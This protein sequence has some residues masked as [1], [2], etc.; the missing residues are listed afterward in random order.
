M[1]AVILLLLLFPHT[2]PLET[3]LLILLGMLISEIY[4]SLHLTYLRKQ[5]P[6]TLPFPLPSG[7]SSNHMDQVILRIALPVS[8]A[9]FFC[10]S[11]STLNSVIIPNLLVQSGLDKTV[12]LQQ[13]GVLFGMTLPLLMIPFSLIN[14][15]SVVLLPHLSRCRVLNQQN[16][17]IKVLKGSFLAIIFFVAPT[18]LLISGFGTQLGTFFYNQPEVGAFILPLAAGVI[19]SAFEVV[20]ET[21]LNACNHQTANACIT[22]SATLIQV[23]VTLAYTVTWGLR[24]YVIG[25]VLTSALGCL[26]RGLLLWRELSKSTVVIPQ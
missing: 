8:L 19:L 4:S 20:I 23:Y 24:A 10:Q 1:A 6:I 13:Y 26:F 17:M 15:L 7:R 21:A 9:T 16:Q 2:S 25:F 5:Q 3:V 12:A 22:L 14:A 11:I 18:T